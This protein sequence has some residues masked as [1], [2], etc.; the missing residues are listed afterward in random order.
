MFSLFGG[1]KN[2]TVTSNSENNKININK[3]I[4]KEKKTLILDERDIIF[5]NKLLLLLTDNKNKLNLDDID[6]THINKIKKKLIFK[7]FA[8]KYI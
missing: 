7:I 5:L 3:K 8:F 1:K 4:K 6:I 2:E